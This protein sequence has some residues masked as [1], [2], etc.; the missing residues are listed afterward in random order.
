MFIIST[1]SCLAGEACG[2]KEMPINIK[3]VAPPL[4]VVMCSTLEISKGFNLFIY[5]NF[6][7]PNV[8]FSFFE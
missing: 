1:F 3:L 7:E 6:Y 4:Y 8:E 5:H 2:T